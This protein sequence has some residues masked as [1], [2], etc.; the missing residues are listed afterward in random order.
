MRAQSVCYLVTHP[1]GCPLT[2]GQGESTLRTGS[3]GLGLSSPN[4]VR[5]MEQEARAAEAKELRAAV[6]EERSRKKIED[7][8]R[9][10]ALE[11]VRE[12][13]VREAELRKQEEAWQRK[14]QEQEARDRAAAAQRIAMDHKARIKRSIF[15]CTCG[16][17]IHADK[18]RIRNAYSQ[19]MWPGAGLG[20]TKEESDLACRR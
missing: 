8:T 3:C 16:N 19:V 14:R 2:P 17:P 5:K 13:E 7:A 10:K 4:Y 18:C 20:L 1:A 11:R 12:E 9:K 6:K 15:K